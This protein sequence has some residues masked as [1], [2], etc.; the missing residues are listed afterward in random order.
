VFTGSRLSAFCF[1]LDKEKPV[2]LYEVTHRVVCQRL[3]APPA[4]PALPLPLP[5]ARPAEDW[6]EVSA[7]PLAAQAGGR[8]RPGHRLPDLAG[9]D[10]R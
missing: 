8:L 10:G 9:G 4:L 3:T 1:L 7:L 2:T 6:R 5:P